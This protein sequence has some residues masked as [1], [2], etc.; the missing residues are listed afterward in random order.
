MIDRKESIIKHL[1]QAFDAVTELVREAD[2]EM[3]HAETPERWSV[4]GHF[5]HLI[6]SA[7]PVASALKRTDE[8]LARLSV[9][10][11]PS[12]TYEGMIQTYHLVL[13]AAGG[14]STPP[15]FPEQLGEMTDE[16]LIESWLMIRD[17]LV[18]R[19]AA[20]SEERLEKSGLPHPRMG[21][22]TMREMMFF[23]IFHTE[24]HHANMSR[25]LIPASS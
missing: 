7:K 13:N 6:L 14:K 25:M 1:H 16:Q 23:T 17:K 12:R 18:G 15:F 11:G 8:E 24:H 5:K 2:A 3:L 9:P 21:P 19:L 22:L 10:N 20:W 4:I